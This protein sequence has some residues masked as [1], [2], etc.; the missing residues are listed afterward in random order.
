MVQQRL[1]ELGE[2]VRRIYREQVGGNPD[3][4]V[5]LWD[6]G[7]RYYVLRDDDTQTDFAIRDL[8][9]ERLDH[10]VAALRRFRPLP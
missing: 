2:K 3:E 5:R 10:I 8:A 4:L 7:G 6:D 9:E 1:F